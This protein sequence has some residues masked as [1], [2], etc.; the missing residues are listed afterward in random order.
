MISHPH[1]MSVLGSEELLAAAKKLDMKLIALGC[2]LQVNKHD[3]TEALIHEHSE[4]MQ[5]R[6]NHN[7]HGPARFLSLYRMYIRAAAP[8]GRRHA[9]KHQELSVDTRTQWDRRGLGG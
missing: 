5:T 9:N 7:A 8:Y 6:Y 2:T 1:L 4:S 3:A